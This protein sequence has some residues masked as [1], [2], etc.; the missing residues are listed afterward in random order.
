MKAHTTNRRARAGSI[1]AFVALLGTSL[2]GAAVLSA[3]TA[4][5]AAPAACDP[6][7]GCTPTTPVPPPAVT[8]TISAQVVSR[9]DVVIG[10][11]HGVLV[12]TLV[13][14]TIDGTTVGQSY[15]TVDGQGSPQ[16]PST[17]SA[18]VYGGAAIAFTVPADFASGAHSFAF[19]GV[20]VS[21]SLGS[22]NV[23]GPS[24]VG[25]GGSGAETGA[26]SGS[27]ARTGMEVALF[28]AIALLLILIG[29][30]LVKAAR[31][32]RRRAVR[33][34]NKVDELV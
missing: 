6:F 10:S 21:C 16:P 3:P 31:R 2:L 18:G 26:K 5:S 32:R 14:L 27:L 8:C 33:R 7:Y 25:G 1:V 34:S 20:N 19:V 15:A 11:I 17:A 13:S 23:L 4:A 12:G 30:S 24:L 28:L 22:V 9:G 29:S